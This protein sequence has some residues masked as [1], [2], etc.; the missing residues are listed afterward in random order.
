V[1]GLGVVTHASCRKIPR[2]CRSNSRELDVIRIPSSFKSITVQWNHVITSVSDVNS[3][4]TLASYLFIAESPQDDV[5]T[6]RNA[7][8]CCVDA[9]QYSDHLNAASRHPRSFQNANG[10]TPHVYLRV[11]A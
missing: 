11:S 3:P 6:P 1:L 7:R 9:G 10:N 8:P 5:A 2:L 4:R